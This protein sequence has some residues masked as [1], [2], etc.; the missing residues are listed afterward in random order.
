V[1]DLS[2]NALSGTLPGAVFCAL[3]ALQLLFLNANQ[4]TR[5]IPSLGCLS[6]QMQTLT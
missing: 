1:L 3:H 6:V 5:A 4:F 2:S